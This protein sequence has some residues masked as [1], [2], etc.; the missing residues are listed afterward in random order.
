MTERPSHSYPPVGDESRF[1]AIVSRGRMIRRRRQMG[2]G[3]GAGGAI[4]VTALAV[5][6][7]TGM[8]TPSEDRG[9]V[10]GRDDS[11]AP[12]TETTTTVPAAPDGITVLLD[13]DVVPIRVVVTD[14]AQP[15]A[16]AEDE[17]AQQCV[18]ATLND[19]GGAA[20]AEGWGCHTGSD[21]VGSGGATTVSLSP[22]GPTQPQI[23]CA[24]TLTRSDPV[25]RS[26]ASVSSTFDLEPPA[27]LASGTYE[28]TVQAV[29]GIGDGCPGTAEG[30]SEAENEAPPTS[31]TVSIP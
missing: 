27:A 19:A 25:E 24:S 1:T 30:S 10:A 7:V 4:A 9:V 6:L 15:V 17:P 21:Q 28:L 14:P 16:T 22:L 8:S 20:V 26:T 29:S 11:T 23:G 12:T 3:A 31:D 13:T 18:L 5:V 2:V